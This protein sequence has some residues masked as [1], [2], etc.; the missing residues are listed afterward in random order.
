VIVVLGRPGLGNAGSVE[1]GEAG[2]A[3]GL[4]GR[5]AAIALAARR[6]GASV[7]LV[8]SVGD[9]PEGDLV[10]VG[11]GAA[12]IGH[13]AVLRDPTARTPTAEGATEAGPLPRLDPGDVSLGLSYLSQC[14]V[15][16]IAEPLTA[17]ANEVAAEAAA[18]H[19][20]AIVAV[21]EEGSPADPGLPETATVLEA[22]AGDQDAFAELVGR[23][24]AA[25]DGGDS[26]AEAFRRA[27]DA[28]GWET[29]RP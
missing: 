14:R 11:L 17:A 28:A 20:A 25:L 18:Y 15:L 5:A 16:V 21:A 1:S 8:G 12:G 10:M 19:G 29:V 7:E 13:A 26:P 6:A 27:R 23:Y 4:H 9:D 3:A 22:A 24:A 2:A